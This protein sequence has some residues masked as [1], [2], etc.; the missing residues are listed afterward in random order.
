MNYGLILKKLRNYFLLRDL[1]GFDKDHSMSLNYIAKEKGDSPADPRLVLEMDPGSHVAEQYRSIRTNL[2]ALSPEEP[3]RAIAITSALKAEGKTITCGNLALAIALEK[4]E[5]VLLIDA[6]L[7]KGELHK[8]FGVDKKPGLCEFLNGEVPFNKAVKKTFCENLF[9][10]PCGRLPDN[11]AELLG[12]QKFRELV[13]AQRTKCDHI[14]LDTAPVIPVTDPCVL[15]KA[16]DGII[17]VVRSRKTS[18]TDVEKAM[19]LLK[20][21]KAKVIGT[22]LTGSITYLPYYRY[23]YKYIY[24]TDRSSS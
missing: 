16:V 6:D 17:L 7:R 1:D 13:D 18:I 8:I 23:K 22:I 24:Q 11:P 9:L 19:E 2:H 20:Y 3:F 14:I 10:I 12:S 21:A 4:E 5:K 15:G